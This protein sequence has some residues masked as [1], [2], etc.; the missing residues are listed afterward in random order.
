MLSSK[1]SHAAAPPRARIFLA[2]LCALA[3]CNAPTTPEESPSTDVAP[4]RGVARLT[5]GTTTAQARAGR[6]SSFALDKAPD[7]VLH[8]QLLTTKYEG[9]TLLLRGK[10]PSGEIV[11]SYPQLVKGTSFDAVIP[12]FGSPAARKH[13]T[14]LYTFQLTA[15]DQSLLASG[16]VTLTSDTTASLAGAVGRVSHVS[17]GEQ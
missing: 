2:L 9:Q 4:L 15:P 11:W 8:A 1:R 5:F 7:L 16:T 14:G 3:A 17:G 10:A 6:T 13:I 12:V